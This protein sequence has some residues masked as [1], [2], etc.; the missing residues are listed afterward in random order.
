MNKYNNT[1]S[2]QIKI[3]NSPNEEDLYQLYQIHSKS[4]PD[5][6]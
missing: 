2:V 1:S 6:I 5:D 4:L 3:L